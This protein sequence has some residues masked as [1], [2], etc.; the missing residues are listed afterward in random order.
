MNI[1]VYYVY[2]RIMMSAE[3]NVETQAFT[4]K[5]HQSVCKTDVKHSLMHGKRVNRVT[6]VK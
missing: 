4:G 3:G 6:H 2:H 5:I 1:Y